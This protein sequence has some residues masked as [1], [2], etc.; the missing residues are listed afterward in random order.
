MLFWFFRRILSYLFALGDPDSVLG[1]CFLWISQNVV[2]CLGILQEFGMGCALQCAHWEGD[3]GN[4]LYGLKEK[5]KKDTIFL[6]QT[7]HVP[8]S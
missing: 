6:K 1:R 3:H 7:I 5:E 8:N 4:L 2:S